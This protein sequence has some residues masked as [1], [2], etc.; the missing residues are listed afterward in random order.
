MHVLP[1]VGSGAR[2]DRRVSRI[3]ASSN[4][5][6]YTP[7]EG[8]SATMHLPDCSMGTEDL[9]APR[10][11][12]S[13][14]VVCDAGDDVFS[15]PVGDISESGAFLMTGRSLPVGTPVS[16]VVSE[17]AE[18]ELPMEM[19][20]EVVRVGDVGLEEAAGGSAGIA[21]RFKGLKVNEYAQLRAFLRRRGSVKNSAT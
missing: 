20:A 4:G 5:V 3:V 18:A 8:R 6:G 1:V 11:E 17:Q 21:F 7:W 13:L 19:K 15:A 2:P 10:Y 16:L 14:T 12:V 9:R